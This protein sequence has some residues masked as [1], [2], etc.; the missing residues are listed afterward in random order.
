MKILI[1]SNNNHKIQEINSI[2]ESVLPGYF[3]FFKL[4]DIISEP[5]DVEET[6]ITLE[7]N[8]IL[9][10]KAYYQIAKMPVLADDTGLEVRALDYKPGVYSARYS[11]KHGDDAA[12]RRLLLKNM[13]SESDRYAHFRTVLCFFDGS[14]EIIVEGKCAGKIAFQ[15]IGDNGFGYDSIFIPEGYSD[16]FAELSTA[17]KNAISHRFKAVMNF[18][19][20]FV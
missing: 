19:K 11:G 13:E 10:A 7:E 20:L 16:T 3:K 15:E 4:D 1:A 17:E 18:A 14:K 5:F 2:C 9:K 8:A 12:N 6:G